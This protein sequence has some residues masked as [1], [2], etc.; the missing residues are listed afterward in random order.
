LA[1]GTCLRRL[2]FS[3]QRPDRF[4][5]AVIDFGGFLGVGSR[6]IAVAWNA[7]RFPGDAKQ[8]DRIALELIRD[9]V[10]TALEFERTS[11]LSS[12]D[13]PYSAKTD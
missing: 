1:W 7:L 4:K 5:T 8:E 13:L 12:S 3:V 6:K 11:Q 9:Q 2:R 10:P